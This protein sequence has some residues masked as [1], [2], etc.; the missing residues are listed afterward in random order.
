M[1]VRRWVYRA[2]LPLALL[3]AGCSGQG[4]VGKDTRSLYVTE[5][6]EMP[7]K[8]A[9]AILAGQV[10]VGM[11]RDMVRAAWG[12]PTRLEK[13]NDHPK[14]DEKW[15]YGNYLASPTVTHLYFK[16]GQLAVYELVDQ[17]MRELESV[18][19]PEKRL[20]LTSPTPGEE[21]GGP[22]RQPH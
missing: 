13:L 11:S 20:L 15:I 21:T 17:Q 6:P 12:E 7:R 3:A 10:V 22:K 18:T 9:D 14:G 1:I 2:W 8:Y 19:D 4:G 16:A 5:H